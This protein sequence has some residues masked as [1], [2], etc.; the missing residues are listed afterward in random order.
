[1]HLP[2][3]VPRFWN[4]TLL[5]ILIKLP[6]PPLTTYHSP[7]IYILLPLLVHYSYY[8]PSHLRI[9]LYYLS[10]TP[11]YRP[12]DSPNAPYYSPINPIMVFVKGDILGWHCLP[13]WACNDGWHL[14]GDGERASLLKVKCSLMICWGTG[15]PDGRCVRAYTEAYTHQH[16][17]TLSAPP[18]L[19][20]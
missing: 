15:A 13:L 4:R 3:I 17:L 11:P 6:L 1:M 10:I 2:L 9:S 18:L 20:H 5:E 19:S 16:T 12:C 7:I 14:S 8:Q